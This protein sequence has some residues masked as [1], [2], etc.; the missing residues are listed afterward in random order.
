MWPETGD[1][2]PPQGRPGPPAGGGALGT[3]RV[4]QARPWPASREAILYQVRVIPRSATTKG[5]TPGGSTRNACP[6]SSR[7]RPPGP[8]G[9]GQVQVWAPP[10]LSPMSSPG[11]PSACLSSPPL[12]IRTRSPWT[13]AHRV[14]CFPFITSVMILSPKQPRAEMPG[15]MP[16]T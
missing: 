10:G 3:S 7:T 14:T 16:P 15:V 2:S 1:K 4:G 9:W 8:G 5:H 6:P 13:R 12:S 11:R